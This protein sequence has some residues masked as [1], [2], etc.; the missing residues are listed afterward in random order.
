MVWFRYTIGFDEM[1][2]Q[3]DG[4]GAHIEDGILCIFGDTTIKA[5]P[6]CAAFKQ[7]DFFVRDGLNEETSV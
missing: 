6:R 2:V 4:T 7:W 5:D 3:I 1:T